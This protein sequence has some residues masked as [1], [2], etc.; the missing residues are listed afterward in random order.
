[1]LADALA[2]AACEEHLR[3]HQLLIGI[4]VAD[5]MFGYAIPAD[6]SKETRRRIAIE[7]PCGQPVAPAHVAAVEGRDRAQAAVGDRLHDRVEMMER[8]RV[9]SGRFGLKGLPLQEEAYDVEPHS[10]D[11][12]HVFAD[13]AEIEAFPH[14]HRAVPRPVVNA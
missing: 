1:M 14:V 5:A 12:C 9:H 3:P 6:R 8:L 13:L 2:D 4:E 11:T 10:L 7:T